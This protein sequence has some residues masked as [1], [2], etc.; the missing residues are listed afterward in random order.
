MEWSRIT[1]LSDSVIRSRLDRTGC[2]IEEAL[3]APLHKD[4]R[5]FLK[6]PRYLY[7]TRDGKTMCL[8]DWATYLGISY[9]AIGHRI[10]RGQ[11]FDSAVEALL[12]KMSH[13][14]PKWEGGM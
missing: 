6:N 8:K 4:S 13:D 11:N 14:D 9:K 1:G 10:R 12:S 5:P 7:F 3:T 2:T